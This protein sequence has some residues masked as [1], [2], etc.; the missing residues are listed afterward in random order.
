[1]CRTVLIPCDRQHSTSDGGS[2]AAVL[3][4]VAIAQLARATWW[5][6]K[7]FTIG[8]YVIAAWTAPRVWRLTR[9]AYRAGRRRWLT[10]TVVL[11]REPVAAITATTTLPVLADLR[12]KEPA[13]S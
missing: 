9:T 6:L 4:G 8:L 7:H 10:R 13:N 1:M 12:L 3:A 2:F 5:M 11:D